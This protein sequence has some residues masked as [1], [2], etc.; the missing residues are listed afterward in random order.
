[1]INDKFYSQCFCAYELQS[2]S[3]IKMLYDSRRVKK[4]HTTSKEPVNQTWLILM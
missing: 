2:L 1:M 4:W 3:L